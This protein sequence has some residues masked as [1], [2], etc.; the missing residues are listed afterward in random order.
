MD[1]TKYSIYW[2]SMYNSP[3]RMVLEIGFTELGLGEEGENDWNT[4]RLHWTVHPEREQDWRD[5]QDKLLRVG[6]TRV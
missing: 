4:I 1:T 2:W 6:K 3:H 5:E